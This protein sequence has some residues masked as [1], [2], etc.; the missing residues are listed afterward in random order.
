MSKT[1]K[2]SWSS[3]FFI[4]EPI[5][6]HRSWNIQLYCHL[7]FRIFLPFSIVLGKVL[8]HFHPCPWS[9]WPSF[10]FHMKFFSLSVSLITL[11]VVQSSGRTFCS[12][13]ACF[14]SFLKVTQHSS[15]FSFLHFGHCSVLVLFIFTTKFILHTTIPCCLAMLSPASTSQL[16]TFL[17]L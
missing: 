5:H 17:R 11:L 13:K 2:M 12:S 1:S 9:P 10:L 4:P 15:L 14:S 8:T 3:D 7:S 16:L 6:P